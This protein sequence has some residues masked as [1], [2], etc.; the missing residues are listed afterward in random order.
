MGKCFVCGAPASERL[1]VQMRGFQVLDGAPV[2]ENRAKEI[3]AAY[4][5]YRWDAK[6]R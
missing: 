4:A 1:N 3:R 5:N 2:C 6:A